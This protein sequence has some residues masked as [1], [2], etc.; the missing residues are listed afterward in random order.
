MAAKEK[1]LQCILT[2]NETLFAQKNLLVVFNQFKGTRYCSE[3]E[4][5]P[6]LEEEESYEKENW[7]RIV[8]LKAE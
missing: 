7:S 5:F 3:T 8:H 1:A 4:E 6:Y 2:Y